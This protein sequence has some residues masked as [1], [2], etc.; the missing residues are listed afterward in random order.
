MYRTIPLLV[1]ASLLSACRLQVITPPEGRVESQAWGYNCPAASSCTFDVD[2][3]SFGDYFVAVP[4]PGYIFYEWQSG[5]HHLCGGSSANCDIS[6][7]YLHF[8][9]EQER[10]DALASD[11]TQYLQP[12]FKPVLLSRQVNGDNAQ[13]LIDRSVDITAMMMPLART[14]VRAVLDLLSAAGDSTEGH[15]PNG[16]SYSARHVDKNRNGALDRGDVVFL[17][18]VFCSLPRLEGVA[19]GTVR[20]Q[21]RGVTGWD[22]AG[23]RYIGAD[24]S[25]GKGLWVLGESGKTVISG[26]HELEYS[27]GQDGNGSVY[28]DT[29]D[30]RG[31][32]L[33]RDGADTLELKYEIDSAIASD[34]RWEDPDLDFYE[35]D[36]EIWAFDE[37]ALSDIFCAA[38]TYWELTEGEEMVGSL[39]HG[40]YKCLGSD[41][42]ELQLDPLTGQ[43]R[44]DSEGDGEFEYEAATDIFQSDR[45]N[46]FFSNREAL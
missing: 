34:Y 14:Q 43:F 39:S 31:I 2:T 12:V 29:G 5:E 11:F 22:S 24:V 35:F 40:T 45:M 32:T 20:L 1:A 6:Y 38:H 3:P 23:F 44:V 13:L 46:G 21:L 8:V 16:G 19:L 18:L 7:N 26:A 36:S 15:C 41:G 10:Q 27:L 42:S 37:T 33:S 4:N 25:H 9:S 28:I 30:D 17:D